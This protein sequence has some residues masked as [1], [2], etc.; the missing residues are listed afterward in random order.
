MTQPDLPDDGDDAK[1]RGAEQRI[2]QRQ[3]AKPTYRPLAESSTVPSTMTHVPARMG[4]VTR[5]PKKAMARAVEIKGFRLV[6]AAATEAPTFSILMNRNSLPNVP[7][8][9]E[10]ANKSSPL[11]TVSPGTS[12]NTAP[13]SPTVPT[14]RLIQSR[15]THRRCAV[16]GG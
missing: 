12:R 3:R 4:R 8:S 13:Q 7:I 10:R 2:E 11:G 1:T 14:A 5:S 6:T 9:P 16:P 15:Y